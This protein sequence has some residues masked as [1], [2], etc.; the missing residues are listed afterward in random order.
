MSV[1]GKQQITRQ[2]S[3]SD[4][5]RIVSTALESSNI[6]AVLSGGAAVSIYTENRYESRDLDFVTSAETELIEAALEPLGF[7]RE[8]NSRYFLHDETDYMLE[9]PPAPLAVGN[10][11]IGEWSQL[12]IGGGVIHILSPTQMVMDRLAAYFHWHDPQS[13]EQALWIARDHT[14]DLQELK[15]WAEAENSPDQ[16]AIFLR[17]AKL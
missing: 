1:N 7:K 2:T 17:R 11:L 14:L 9:F 10:K 16:F 15:E 13:L 12:E 4:L 6:T 3:V 5:A 8:K